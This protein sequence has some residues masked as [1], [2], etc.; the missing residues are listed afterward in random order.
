MQETRNKKQVFLLT[1]CGFVI[2]LA[3]VR[4]SSWTPRS[5]ALW[6]HDWNQQHFE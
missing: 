2:F 3:V 5:E 4:Q 1:F 6:P